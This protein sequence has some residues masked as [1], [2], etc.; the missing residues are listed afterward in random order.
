[1][2]GLERNL[3]YCGGQ[4]QFW[5]IS[6]CSWGYPP[7]GGVGYCGALGENL[8]LVFL[9]DSQTLSL[10]YTFVAKNVPLNIQILPKI[11]RPYTVTGVNI[12]FNR[13]YTD[14]D[15]N[16]PFLNRQNARDSLE[17]LTNYLS[18]SKNI[19]TLFF[20]QQ[21]HPGLMFEIQNSLWINTWYSWVILLTLEYAVRVIFISL[22][23]PHLSPL[24][25]TEIG[26][27]LIHH[28]HGKLS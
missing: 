9:Q 20:A 22:D 11:T 17:V 5:Y 23:I 18:L 10:E 26:T 8:G 12:L 24:E 7:I 19:K 25:N 1:M 16:T 27:A 15:N 13:S 28:V 14:L 4:C 3:G 21:T 6:P 2:L